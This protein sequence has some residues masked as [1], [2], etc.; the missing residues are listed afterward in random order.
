VWLAGGCS[1]FRSIII[2]ANPTFGAAAKGAHMAIGLAIGNSD[3]GYLAI[4]AAFL[5]DAFEGVL[6]ELGLVDSSDPAR[7]AVANH[8]I[9]FAKAGERDPVRL[10]DLTLEAVRR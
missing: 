10:Q 8:I 5:V 3:N 2:A 7:L 9:A 6:K 1:L 4:D